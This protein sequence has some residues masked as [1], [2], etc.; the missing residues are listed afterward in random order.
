MDA[1]ANSG[2]AAALPPHEGLTALKEQ[3]GKLAGGS[4]GDHGVLP[5]GLAEIDAALPGGG[6]ALGALHELSGLGG[7]PGLTPNLA[8]LS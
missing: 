4:F 7:E 8:A 6:L 1:T 3:I 2:L 5:F